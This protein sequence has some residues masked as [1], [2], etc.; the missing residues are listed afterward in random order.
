MR[1]AVLGGGPGGLY[2]AISMKLRDPAHEVVVIERNR[3][4]DT[5]G[6]GVVLSDE[7]LANLAAND[8]RQRRLRSARLRLLGRHRRALPRHG[9]ALGGPRLLR[10]RPQ[11][12]A[13]HPAGP[14]AR[15]RRRAAAS[16]P[17][18]TSAD[19]YTRLRPGRRRRRRQFAACAPPMPT[20]SSP[21]STCAPASTSGSAR[22]RNSTTPSPSSSRRPSTAGSGRTPTSSTPTPRP[23][24]SN[25]RRRPGARLGFDAMTQR[26]D[27][28]GLR[29]D[30]RQASRRPCADVERQASARLGLAQFPPRAVRALVARE[31]RADGR[32][33]RHRA[34]LDRLRHQARAGKRHR[35]GRLPAQRAR[36]RRPPSAAT[37]TSADRGAAAAERGAQLDRMVRGGRALSRTSIRC[38]STIRCSPARSAS[39]TRT[40]ALR[41]PEWL[42]GAE[43]WFER[44]GDRARRRTPRGR[45]CSRRSGCAASSC[46]NRVVRLADG[47]VQARSTAARPTGTSCT[48]PSAPRAA[49]GWSITEMTCVVAGG[50]HHARLHRPLQRPSTSAPGSGS[51]ISCTPRPTPRSPSSS[52]IPAPRARPSSAGKTIGRAAAGGNW[53]VIGAVAGA[54]GR[55][56]NQVPREMTRADMDRVRDEFVRVGRDGRRAPASTCSSCTPRTATCCRPSSRRSPTSAPTNTAARSRTACA[57]RSRS[58]APCA[59]CGRTSKP[60]SVRISANDWVGAD[61]V[62]P[63]DAVEIARL[64]QEAGV[65]I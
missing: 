50:P 34:F 60:I 9:H 16:R 63:Q 46:K 8:P 48:T 42:D 10:H 65:D 6:W 38:S 17:R 37:R 15:A 55:R 32:R 40:C 29:A 49:P 54:R 4:D 1:A 7:T 51:S 19:A 62:T 26:G 12:A 44:A 11:A 56:D 41:D 39:A 61:G 5:F 33:R 59:R 24:S 57:F 64:L 3:P 21:T 25:A 27:D 13:R 30:L 14:R 58:S 2:F 18:S 23:S 47:A 53:P 31:H 35:A 36:P 28:R 22:T 45:R 52:A 20:S 43:K